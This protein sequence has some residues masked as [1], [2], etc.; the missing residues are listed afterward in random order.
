[1]LPVYVIVTY[2][3]TLSLLPF[4]GVFW[5]FVRRIS[6]LFSICLYSAISG[7]SCGPKTD[8]FY[9]DF[10]VRKSFLLYHTNQVHL[11]QSSRRLIPRQFLITTL[12]IQLMY[13]FVLCYAT[14]KQYWHNITW[15]MLL[16][17]PLKISGSSFTNY[18]KRVQDT[19]CDS[20]AV[21]GKTGYVA[22]I[23]FSY[24]MMWTYWK[25]LW[26]A[27]EFDFTPFHT[28]KVV[29]GHCKGAFCCS[30]ITTYV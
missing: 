25:L 27:F 1:M 11:S 22:V 7:F 2:R 3:G 20:H 5:I 10:L 8:Q 9:C 30:D 6:Q 17:L 26:L 16:I 15:D 29:I 14:P 12:V 23:L 19:S 18:I 28:L 21:R 4:N 24:C 13:V